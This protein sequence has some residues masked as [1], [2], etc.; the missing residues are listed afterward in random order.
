MVGVGGQP[1]PNHIDSSGQMPQP[2]VLS[3]G[4]AAAPHPYQ[5]LGYFTGF[6]EPVM[7]NA[8]KAQRS[9]RKSAPG[10]DHIKHRRTRSGCYTC[11]SR[12]VKCDETRPICERCRKGKRECNYPEPP[13]PKGSGGTGSKD[14][15]GPSQQ[16]SPTSSRGDD[17]EEA[18]QDARLNPILDEEEDEPESATSQ[19]SAPNFPLRRSSTTSSFSR[20]RVV[21]G[22]RQGSETPS[23]E[24]NKSESPALPSGMTG[25]QTPAKSPFPDVPNIAASA[26]PD[27]TF[28]PH[29]LQFYLGYFY[30]NVTHYH[31][32]AVND[33]DDFFRSILTGL[34]MRDEALLYAVVGFSAYHHSMKNP[35]GKINEFL[36][37]YSRSVTLLLECMKKEKYTVG[38][39][40]TILQLATIEEYLGDW[41]NLM[42]HQKAAF[43]VFTK[44]FTP[45]TVMQTP[46]GRAALTWYARF[47]VFLGIMGSFKTS[48]CREWFTA[49]VDYYESRAAEEPHNLAW[50]IEACSAQL[51]LISQQM[52]DLFARGAKQEITKDEYVAE[53]RRLSVVWDEWKNSWDS[54]LKNP[55]CLV[56]EF[57]GNPTPSPDDIVNP[58]TPGV[59][60]RPPI[61]AS[62]LMTCEYHSISL[63]HASQNAM[64][65][66]EEDRVRLMEHAYAIC[67]IFE[68]VE[69]WPQSPAGSLTVLQ[70]SIAIAALYL[71]RD[72]K[73]HMWF[74]RKFVLLESIG[75]ISPITLRTR[76]AELF[77]DET[78]VRWWLPN[79]EDFTPLLQNIRAIADERNAMALS[80]QRESLQ[81]IRH[82]FARMQIGEEHAEGDDSAQTG[83]KRKLS[84][85]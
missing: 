35:N 78:C 3:M 45:Q 51:R 24:G 65:L 83:A 54:A 17:D 19:T 80:T 21:P 37:Y 56:D 25:A 68:A 71:P 40:L 67:Q 2:Q 30:D 75:Y 1:S 79:D 85:A 20:Q 42:G 12:R 57:P 61:F 28:L 13:P 33:A 4:N 69:F 15:A 18:E 53:H 72:S 22:Q 14:S 74:R 39:L 50:K 43:E 52:S 34:A 7:F 73:H 8:P 55:G 41:V 5:S 47:D 27:W 81:Q 6:P 10:L 46:V 84:T 82:N 49:P 44:L 16:P 70:S 59:L 32:C 48:L 77:N 60:F 23:Y 38:T 58:F 9:R 64:K 31:Y 63:M 26:R 11:R 66:T 76:M 62:T 36:Q 29:E